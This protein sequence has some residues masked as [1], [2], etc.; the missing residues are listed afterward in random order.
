M[1]SS[2]VFHTQCLPLSTYYI[3][4]ESTIFRYF[5]LNRRDNG[6]C[7]SKARGENE[8]EVFLRFKLILFTGAS[9]VSSGEC[10]V[11]PPQGAQVQSLIGELRSH[12]LCGVAKREEKQKK[13]YSFHC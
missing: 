7:D 10:S 9:P 11:L 3:T 8:V 13:A 12:M 4:L 6:S 5:T 2:F 1:D